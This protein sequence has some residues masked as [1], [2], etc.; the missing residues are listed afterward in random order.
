MTV[1]TNADIHTLLEHLNT[2]TAD[3]L[4]TQW[5]EFKPWNSPRDDMK[6]AIEYAVCFANAEGGVIVFGVADRTRSRV[7]A[8]HGASN[9]NLD[10]WRRGIFD[11]TRPNLSVEVKE[12]VIPEGTGKLLLVRVSQGSNPPY[13]T[14]QGLFKKR[15]GKNCMPLD[16][17][18]FAQM[19]ISTG[20]VDWSGQPAEDIHVED[21]DS[22][23]VSRARN[24]LRRINPESE[25]L[26]L[27]DREFLL[28]L[29]AIRQGRVTHT[30]ILLFGREQG[31]SE[32]C[33]QHQ[34]HYVYEASETQVLRNDSHRAGL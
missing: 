11:A 24:I 17:Q 9:Y 15:V 1:P 14:A 26:K 10:I 22:V 34:V 32:L 25:L 12:L 2:S 13:G 5:L 20:A 18:G 27:D 23:E 33:P 31:L 3:D 7:A 29:G 28:G 21:L 6:I 8:L 4:E 16:P 19:R 30:G